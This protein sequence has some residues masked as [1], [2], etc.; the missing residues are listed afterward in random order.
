MNVGFGNEAAQLH[1]W[2]YRNRIFG[3]VCGSPPTLLPPS[4]TTVSH[5]C[6][7]DIANPYLTHAQTALFPIHDSMGPYMG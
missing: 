2:E 3:P 7:K 4:H 6:L 5:N 1:F